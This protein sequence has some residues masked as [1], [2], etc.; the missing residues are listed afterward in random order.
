MCGWCWAIVVDGGPTSTQQCVTTADLVTLK[1]QLTCSVEPLLFQFWSIVCDAGPTLNQQWP[2]VSYL[3]GRSSWSYQQTNPRV[4]KLP[5]ST[6]SR[7]RCF[8]R[9]LFG[10]LDVS[11]ASS[12]HKIPN[13]CCFNVGLLSVTVNKHWINVLWL[14]CD[15]S[16]T[17]CIF[18][19]HRCV[20]MGTILFLFQYY[21][22]KHDTL[23]QWCF[24][25]GPTFA[26]LAQH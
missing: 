21:P 23:K 15:A 2:S 18:C 16:K 19:K 11:K 8:V 25:F 6:T 5:L 1:T 10:K 3:L 7:N 12:L 22:S 9:G 20:E 17:A 26:T 14:L 4:Q 24:N 13:Q